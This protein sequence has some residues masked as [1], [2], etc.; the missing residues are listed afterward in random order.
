[1]SILIKRIFCNHQYK[2]IN[3][4]T[5]IC[6]K[7]GK[8]EKIPCCHQYETYRTYY[9]KDDWGGNYINHILICKN[10]GK[11]IKFKGT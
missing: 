7:C 9:V 3:P 10:C 2:Q 11:V 6:E 5:L 4:I 8:I 1:M